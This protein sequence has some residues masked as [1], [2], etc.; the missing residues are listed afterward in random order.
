MHQPQ[1]QAMWSMQFLQKTFE[2]AEELADEPE[3]DTEVTDAGIHWALLADRN[4]THPWM[5]RNPIVCLLTNLIA[6]RHA[7][8]VPL[9]STQ[10]GK[11][12]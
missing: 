1:R 6:I 3:E 7:S 8:W 12:S 4:V 5:R 2:L 11:H 9:C 10:P